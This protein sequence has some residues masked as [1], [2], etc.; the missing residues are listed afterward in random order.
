MHSYASRHLKD[1]FPSFPSYVAF[2][3]RL[4][5]I[6]DVFVPLIERLQNKLPS[7]V[8]KEAYQLIDSM[9]IILAQR[10]RRFNAK[11]APEIATSNGYCATKKLHYYDVK[12]H[13]LTDYKKVSLPVPRLI[14]LTDAGTHDLRAYEQVVSTL[15]GS[16]V[17][18]DKAYQTENKPILIKNNI[19]LHTSKKRKGTKIS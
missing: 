17:Y 19:I 2:V 7:N 10:G 6:Q 5:Q 9:P 1:W 13:I 16:E 11:V 18:A 14:G 15:S 3:Q 8:Q 4:N 12:L